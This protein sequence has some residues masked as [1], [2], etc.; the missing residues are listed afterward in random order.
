MPDPVEIIIRVLNE[1]AVQ[2]FRQAAEAGKQAYREIAQEEVKAQKGSRE[3]AEREA[4]VRRGELRQLVGWYRQTY[5]DIKDIATMSVKEL[6]QLDKDYLAASKINLK[7]KADV[8]KQAEREV[9]DIIKA[10]TKFRTEQEKQRRQEISD[11]AKMNRDVNRMVA[12]EQADTMREAIKGNRE[13]RD[14]LK[15]VRDQMVSVSQGYMAM[16]I[17]TDVLM[18]VRTA[19]MAVTE[20]IKE[21]R[22]MMRDFL[23]QTEDMVKSRPFRELMSLKGVVPTSAAAASQAGAAAAA[24]LSVADYNASEAQFLNYA[25]QQYIQQVAPGAAEPTAAELAANGKKISST[26]SRGLFQKAATY[27][28]GVM[29]LSPE[30]SMKALGTAMA[31][32][33]PGSSESNILDLYSKILALGQTQTGATN[34]AIGQLSEVAL[35][36]AGEN[37]DPEAVLRSMERMRPIA[38]T[39][40]SKA[41]TYGKAYLRAIRQ[42][43]VEAP[44]KREKGEIPRLDELGL[45]G[46]ADADIDAKIRDARAKHLAKRTAEGASATDADAEF[47]GRYFNEEREFG[48]AIAVM[49]KPEQIEAAKRDAAKATAK[50]LEQANAGFMKQPE[51][52]KK[53]AQES[54]EQQA[55]FEAGAEQVSLSER[56]R[57]ARIALL[58][59]KEWQRPQG[60]MGAMLTQGGAALGGAEGMEFDQQTQA[61]IGRGIAQDFSNL[62]NKGKGEQKEE[63]LRQMRVFMYQEQGSG[64]DLGAAMR[65]WKH[66]GEPPENALYG[67]DTDDA[68]LMRGSQFIDEM[69]R[70]TAILQQMQA[71]LSGGVTGSGIGIG[72]LPSSILAGAIGS[73]PG[74]L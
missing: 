46:V 29:G 8:E 40:P 35:Q 60:V 63:L 57:L 43:R 17:A 5:A 33:P 36:E 71:N 34:P 2:G 64:L 26:T 19:W 61:E 10:D 67:R 50:T 72:D 13:H 21:S 51:G 25:G 58:R 22:S 7:A 6:M 12:R 54:T 31:A 56:R 27:G 3:A 65:R 18:G 52:G 70:Q 16:Q 53:F 55:I 62:R 20:S 14:A 41:A 15:E 59:G 48:G 44:G 4:I 69:K 37:P 42:M 47:V 24:G 38:Q 30:E 73:F 68:K 66:F 39:Y 49:G 32:S 45:A 74:R 9:M 1:Q 11:T 23:K 28:V